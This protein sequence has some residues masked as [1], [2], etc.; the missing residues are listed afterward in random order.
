MYVFHEHFNVGFR[1]FKLVELFDRMF[2]DGPSY[3]I[4]D[5]DEGVGFPTVILLG[6]YKWV[7][8]G[9]FVLFG[10]FWESIVAVCEF[11]ELYCVICGGGG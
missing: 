8:F 5:C 11:N 9:V 3:S 6:L 10:L 1:Y 7:V 4:N 2:V